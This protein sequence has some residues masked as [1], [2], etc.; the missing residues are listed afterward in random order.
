MRTALFLGLPLALLASACTY[1]NGDARRYTDPPSDNSP[2]SCGPAIQSTI[3]VDRQIEVQAGEGA[4]VF[5]EYTSGGHWQLRTT[6]DSLKNNVACKWD[7]IVTPEDGQTFSNVVATDLEST[8]A[9]RPFPDDTRSYQLIAETSGDID[10]FTFDTAAGAA[11][12]VDALIDDQCALPYFFWIG[13]GAL[14]SGSPSNPVIL[15]PSG[16]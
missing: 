1:D 2:T 5:I 13:D 10:G 8:D 16:E 14:H 4:G 11:I 15:A 9:V 6:C 12:S 7:I 3:D